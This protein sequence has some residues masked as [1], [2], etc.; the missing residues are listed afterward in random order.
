MKSLDFPWPS[1]IAGMVRTRVGL[2]EKGTFALTVEEAKKVAISGPWLVKLSGAKIEGRYLPAPRD[3]VAYGQSAEL[4]LHRLKPLGRPA[5]VQSDLPAGLEFVGPSGA[6]NEKAARGG[7]AFW[8]WTR[9]EKWLSAP[10]DSMKVGSEELG[11]PALDHERRVHVALD[12]ETQT[13]ADGQL[14]STD[15]L[16]FSKVGQSLALEFSANDARLQTGLATLGGDRRVSFLRRVDRWVPALPAAVKAVGRRARVVLV[17]P[18][19]FKNGALPESIGGAKVVA[20]VVPRAEVI[21]GFD[22]SLGADGRARGPKPSRRAV[23]AGSVFWVDLAGLDVSAWLE[24]VWWK[25]ISDDEQDRR[26]GF[27]LAVVGVE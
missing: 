18:A 22:Q 10:A 14:F 19:L 27:G 21:S 16:R 11:L 6:P 25:E 1:T 13:A 24:K 4:T 9:L 23:A 8:G 26:D 3:V 5:S 2:D 7:A 20:A 17:T 12:P 15:G